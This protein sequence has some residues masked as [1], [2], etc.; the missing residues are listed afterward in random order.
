VIGHQLKLSCD[1]GGRRPE[2]S[3]V[4][5]VVPVVQ[6]AVVSPLGPGA[7]QNAKLRKGRDP[8]GSD[9]DTSN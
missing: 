4:L 8:P 2:L 1:P 3:I 6:T 9:I 5:L 7:L